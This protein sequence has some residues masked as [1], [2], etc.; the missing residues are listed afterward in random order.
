[1]NAV[2]RLGSADVLLMCNRFQVGGVYTSALPT[3]MI[4]FQTFRHWTPDQLKGDNMR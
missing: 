1:M 2:R 4:N 3:K